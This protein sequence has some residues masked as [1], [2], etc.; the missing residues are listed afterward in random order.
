M[1]QLAGPSFEQY[2]LNAIKWAKAMLGNTKYI[3]LCLAFVE[4]AYEKS[5]QIEMFGGDTAKESAEQY[6]A[7][8]N[9]GEPPLGS[10]VF[11][12]WTGRINGV[13]K[14]WGHVGLSLGDGKI[15]HAWDKV[16]IDYWGE[17]EKIG[18]PPDSSSLTYIGWV[19]PDIFL[20]GFRKL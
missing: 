5:N 10:L 1:E 8:K 7:K 9:T 14:N 12:N 16:R 6:G 2:C 11:Y 13:V 17:M 20:L 18:V 19:S 4:D 3:G 15:I